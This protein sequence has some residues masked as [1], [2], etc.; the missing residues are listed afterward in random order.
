MLIF[1]ISG[2][3]VGEKKETKAFR[4]S[5]TLPST[6]PSLCN[7]HVAKTL[8]VLPSQEGGRQNQTIKVNYAVSEKKGSS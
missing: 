7:A 6:Q 8:E 3:L 4:E 5:Q 2:C 1:E